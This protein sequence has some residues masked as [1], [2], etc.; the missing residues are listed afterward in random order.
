MIFEGARDVGANRRRGNDRL[1]W[2][3]AAKM[4]LVLSLLLWVAVVFVI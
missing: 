4:L 1:P 3:E 2:P